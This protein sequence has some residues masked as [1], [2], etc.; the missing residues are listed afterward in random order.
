MSPRRHELTDYEWSLLEPLL[1]PQRGNG[2]PYHDHRTVLNGM[3]WRLHT[4]TAWRDLPER[5][6]SW[7]TVYSRF[8]RWQ[9]RGLWDRILARLHAELDRTGRVDWTQ[10]SV[11]GSNVRAH[12]AAAG[13]RKKKL[14]PRRAR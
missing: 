7:R 8:A 13:A 5:Y 10:F 14:A 9:Q 3:L 4:G 1:P 2:R 11:D 12:R 6:G